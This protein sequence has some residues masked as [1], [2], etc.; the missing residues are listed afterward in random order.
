M[1]P[2]QE[3]YYKQQTSTGHLGGVKLA[4]SCVPITAAHRGRAGTDVTVVIQL[5]LRVVWGSDRM[6][7]AGR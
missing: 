6:T 1:T 4:D 7:H 2:D 3:Q 5:K